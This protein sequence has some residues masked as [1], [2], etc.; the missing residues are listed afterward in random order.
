MFEKKLEAEFEM[1][2]MEDDFDDGYDESDAKE[3]EVW[4][5]LS[6]IRKGNLYKGS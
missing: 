6:L 3:E 2:P 5:D 1:A 4:S